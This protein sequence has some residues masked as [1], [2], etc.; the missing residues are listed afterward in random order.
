MPAEYLGLDFSAAAVTC[1]SF[2]LAVAGASQDDISD[3]TQAVF[4][5]D[6]KLLRDLLTGMSWIPLM[7]NYPS[8]ESVTLSLHVSAL[9][10]VSITLPCQM[11]VFCQVMD[12][13]V[14]Y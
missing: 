8:I 6:A 7:L 4:P 10:K 14:T 11:M 12:S 1:F 3:E 5:E 13:F 2:F 9:V